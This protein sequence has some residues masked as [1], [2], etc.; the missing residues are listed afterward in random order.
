[1][2]KIILS[3]NREL[4]RLASE[5]KWSEYGVIRTGLISIVKDCFI[6]ENINTN[7]RSYEDDSSLICCYTDLE[8]SYDDLKIYDA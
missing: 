2:D 7:L 8:I 6:N 5:D 3:L 4:I 1:M